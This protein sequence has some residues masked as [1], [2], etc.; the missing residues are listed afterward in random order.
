MT[1]RGELKELRG[2]KRR[3]RVDRLR[4]RGERGTDK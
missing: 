3:S 2:K 4:Q 1:V